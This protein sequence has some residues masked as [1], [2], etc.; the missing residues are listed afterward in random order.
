MIQFYGRS[1]S[2]VSKKEK[3]WVLKQSAYQLMQPWRHCLCYGHRH[4]RHMAI[5]HFWYPNG[6]PKC[7]ESSSRRAGQWLYR[8]ISIRRLNISRFLIPEVRTHQNTEGSYFEA[9]SQLQVDAIHLDKSSIPKKITYLSQ[10]FDDEFYLVVGEAKL[11]QLDVVSL[12][13]TCASLNLTQMNH[14]SGLLAC[15]T[16][17]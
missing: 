10:L 12:L 4:V 2:H 17:R 16:V 9:M 14:Q 1:L 5:L 15:G 6:L 7:S 8:C 13:H 11:S 3:Q